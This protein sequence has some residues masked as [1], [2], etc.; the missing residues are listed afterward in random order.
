MGN[1]KNLHGHNGK[2]IA[3]SDDLQRLI[4]EGNYHGE[5]FVPPAEILDGKGHHEIQDGEPARL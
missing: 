4:D 3:S 5:W 2:N 1:I